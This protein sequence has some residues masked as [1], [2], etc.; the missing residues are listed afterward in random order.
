M[1]LLINL[2]LLMVLS[3][4]LT[5]AVESG[6]SR[7]GKVLVL[8]DSMDMQETHSKFFQNVKNRGFE[9]EFATISTKSVSLR[10]W[11]VWQY[12]KL[13]IFGGSQSKTKKFQ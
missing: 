4:A 11:D 7:K 12:D 2:A 1:R 6:I 5:G 3:C 9:M 10:D 8:L 13:M